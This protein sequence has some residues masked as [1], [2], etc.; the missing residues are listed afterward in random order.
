M[1][2]SWPGLRIRRSSSAVL[3]CPTPMVVAAASTLVVLAPP[4]LAQAPTI[5]L[6][7]VQVTGQRILSTA[8]RLDEDL[9]R[10]PFSAS[11]VD[12]AQMDATGAK[13]L[14][15]ALRSVPGLQHGTQGNFFTR[16]ETR[17]LRDT[18]D[19]LVLV[20]GVPLRLLQGNADVTLI[21]PDLLERVEFIKGPA[22]A[23]YGKNAIGGVVQFFLEP[24]RAGGR[25]SVTAG[26]FGRR[27]VA[28]RQRW[29]GARGHL[30]AGAAYSH[31]DGFQA[32]TPRFQ[33]A[34][35]LSGDVAL[36][37][38]WVTGFQGYASRVNAQRGSI[39]PLQ[40]GRPMFGITPRD[41]FAI[42]G[43][44]IDGEYV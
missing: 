10:V 24:E 18:Q 17:G 27:D 2:S 30:F 29:D 25:A 32:G 34:A 23:V 12:R 13:T 33:S 9:L 43:V 31:T 4:A 6:A 11:I 3:A 21:A 5:E 1:A 26:S 37:S 28:A 14:E 41:N 8:S 22:S 44:A 42:P 16:F 36:G 20:D 40:D 19:V 15:E 39:V 38:S 7:P 35:V